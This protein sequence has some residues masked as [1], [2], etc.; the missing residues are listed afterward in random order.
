MEHVVR[1]CH[2]TPG[3]SADGHVDAGNVSLVSGTRLG[4]D[5]NSQRQ[6]AAYS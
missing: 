6:M 4:H 3:F 5:V 1:L 2:V